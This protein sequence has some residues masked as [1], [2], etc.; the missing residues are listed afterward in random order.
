MPAFSLLIAAASVAGAQSVV[1][2][3]GAG[4]EARPESIVGM[5]PQGVELERALDGRDP[6]V[7]GW[8]RVRLVTGD[9][10]EEFNDYR[11]T[12]R[13][14]WRAVARIERGDAAAAEPLF[15]SLAGRYAGAAGPT[16]SAIS[17]GLLR[18]RLRRGAVAGGVRAWLELLRSVRDSGSTLL[19]APRLRL[20]PVLDR[21]TGL[22]PALPPMWIAGPELAPLASR[23]MPDASSGRE[24]ALEAWYIVA[25]RAELGMPTP[26]PGSGAADPSGA[27]AF[28]AQIV[29]ARAGDSTTRAAARGILRAE[30][31]EV[32]SGSEDDRRW[33]AAW[34]HAA[35]GRSL[36]AEPERE[37]KL[38]GV[39]ELLHVPALYEDAVLGLSTLCIEESA[40]TLVE[41]GLMESAESLR[42]YENAPA[43]P[44]FAV[45]PEMGAG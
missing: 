31:L 43:P 25:A 5:G 11:D 34:A 42:R 16:S 21:E 9:L 32:R 40:R 8:H 12:A 33:R 23:E 41:L 39:A 27:V 13:D 30:T 44:G 2:R 38:R 26:L 3:W 37:S 20:R 28:V 19:W 15:E 6:G 18:C 36:I 10:E 35:I 14:A 22:V 45:R 17:E 4:P 29:R 24:S 7:L 1:H